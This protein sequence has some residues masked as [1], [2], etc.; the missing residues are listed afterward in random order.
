MAAWTGDLGL[1][2]RY[3]EDPNFKIKVGNYYQLVN[4]TYVFIKSK[5]KA[6]LQKPIF[7]D[8]NEEQ[9]SVSGFS[10]SYG[11]GYTKSIARE[12]TEEEYLTSIM[13]KVVESSMTIDANIDTGIILEEGKFYQTGNGTRVKIESILSDGTSIAV[14]GGL[15]NRN[16]T[17]RPYDKELSIVLEYADLT[18]SEEVQSSNIQLTLKCGKSYRNR[19]GGIVRIETSSEIE[20]GTTIFK[21]RKDFSYN[22]RGQYNWVS[23]EESDNDLIEELDFVDSLLIGL[24]GLY[25]TRDGQV[26]FI[27]KQEGE[28]FISDLGYVYRLDGKCGPI[29]DNHND[30][31]EDITADDLV[32]TNHY[33]NTYTKVGK[34]ESPVVSFSEPKGYLSTVDLLKITD[35]VDKI[36]RIANPVGLDVDVR[37]TL[38][39]KEGPGS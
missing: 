38:A 32:L 37:L 15:Y 4:E 34:V 21:D 24:H 8:Q 19:G 12:A 13:P 27:V 18:V 3:L 17:T 6:F 14:G 5:K 25:H 16:G 11:H 36:E 29:L 26:V 9:Y 22:S 39:A 33:V 1:S 7:T 31:V 20:N 28:Q 23:L 35:Y 30:I 2:P 10:L